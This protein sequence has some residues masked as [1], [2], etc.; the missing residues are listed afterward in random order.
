[1]LCI[2]R[3]VK[4]TMEKIFNYSFYTYINISIWTLLWT[5]CKIV[6]ALPIDRIG[7]FRSRVGGDI[8]W[9][10]MQSDVSPKSRQ[11]ASMPQISGSSLH[12]LISA[13]CIGCSSDSFGGDS[14]IILRRSLESQFHV[15]SMLRRFEAS[16]LKNVS[17]LEVN[18]TRRRRC[19]NCASRISYRHQFANAW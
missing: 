15:Y 3:G 9:G 18:N 2:G 11:A 12:P 4:G 1:M 8:S 10:Q 14:T 16:P 5:I 6:E 7:H 13:N 19:F 17:R